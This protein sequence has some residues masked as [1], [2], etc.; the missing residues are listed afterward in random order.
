MAFKNSHRAD[1]N[2]ISFRPNNAELAGREWA[3]DDD[4]CGEA[5]VELA[6]AAGL[7]DDG[8]VDDDGDDVDDDSDVV[9]VVVVEL[10]L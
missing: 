9:V 7:D 10:P 8:D 5:I 1:S 3:A 2:A 6:L 4:I